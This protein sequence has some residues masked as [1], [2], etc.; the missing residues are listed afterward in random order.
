MYQKSLIKKLLLIL[1]LAVM[2]LGI[3]TESVEIAPEGELIAVM[4]NPAA[5]YCEDLG[6]IYEV[7]SDPSGEFGICSFSDGDTC[8]AWE[9]LEGK[10]GQSHSYCA[11]H[12][13]DIKTVTD[14]KDPF[15]QE[16]AVCISSEGEEVGSVT[17]L[18]NLSEKSM[19]CGADESIQTPPNPRGKGSEGD[20]IQQLAPDGTPPSAFNWNDI[21]GCD[22]LTSI[23]DQGDCG[24]CWAFS[25][26]GAAEAAH[27]IGADDITLDLDLSEQ[28]LVSDCYQYSG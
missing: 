11:L 9:F 21:Q 2:A 18:S 17:E 8:D 15:S 1:G 4:A 12:G 7:V 10:C 3:T 28:Y 22:W 14:G 25:A 27:N 13:Y 19:R 23:K 6:Y 16:Y 5:V 20:V 26:V 24:S